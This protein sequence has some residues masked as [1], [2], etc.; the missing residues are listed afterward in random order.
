MASHSQNYSHTKKLLGSQVRNDKVKFPDN[1]PASD[2]AKAVSEMYK[3]KQ[4][5]GLFLIVVSSK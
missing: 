3:I 5:N 1:T 4:F 2:I